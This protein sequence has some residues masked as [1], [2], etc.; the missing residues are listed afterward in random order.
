MV[1]DSGA[2]NRMSDTVQ[3]RAFDP[4]CHMQKR[5]RVSFSFV[6][7]S[8]DDPAHRCMRQRPL[9]GSDD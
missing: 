9:I 6:E 7:A 5:V 2:W 8:L 3:E 4:T 1:S